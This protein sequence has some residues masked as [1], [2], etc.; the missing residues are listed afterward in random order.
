M[1]DSTILGRRAFVLQEK[2]AEVE[3]GTPPLETLSEL[4]GDVLPAEFLE[5]REVVADSDHL[6]DGDVLVVNEF[7][8]AAPDAKLV[9]RL[10]SY[11]GGDLLVNTFRIP[12]DILP[13][14][15][16]LKDQFRVV[17]G[18]LVAVAM[19]PLDLHRYRI[20]LR[21][22][23]AFGGQAFPADLDGRRAYLD[24]LFRMLADNQYYM[25]TGR[26]RS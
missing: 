25:H 3:R 15:V 4:A 19:K 22:Q 12:L 18:G 8:E 9:S 24:A 1:P 21:A 17:G 14:G 23:R 11:G 6:R 5:V 2:S 10:R 16:R 26:R 20:R 13:Q 7:Y